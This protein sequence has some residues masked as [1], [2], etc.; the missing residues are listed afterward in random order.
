M[1]NGF[2]ERH[3]IIRVPQDTSLDSILELLDE[4]QEERDLR[5]ILP[6]K[7]VFQ[8][9]KELKEKPRT[10]KWTY[11]HL[12]GCGRTCYGYK[13]YIFGAIKEYSPSTFWLGYP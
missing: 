12:L 1:Y 7:I 4:F 11:T 2:H 8:I 6:Y 9:L 10:P 5:V 3:N 13:A